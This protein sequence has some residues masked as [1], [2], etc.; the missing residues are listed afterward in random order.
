MMKN[1]VDHHLANHTPS[2][3]FFLLTREQQAQEYLDDLH[4][5]YPKMYSLRERNEDKRNIIKAQHKQ[6]VIDKYIHNRRKA[7]A[8]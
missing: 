3:Q 7:I 2:K 1:G 6:E 8:K 4:K 5:Q